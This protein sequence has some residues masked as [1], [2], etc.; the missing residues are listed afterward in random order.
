MF[1]LFLFNCFILNLKAKFCNIKRKILRGEEFS[2]YA[3]T[4]LK[5][6]PGYGGNFT[7]ASTVKMKIPRAPRGATW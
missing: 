5:S 3:I 6:K 4:R 2:D 7:L 1:S